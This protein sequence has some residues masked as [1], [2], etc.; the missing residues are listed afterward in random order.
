MS[1]IKTHMALPVQDLE[2]TRRFYSQLFDSEPAKVKEDY[3]KFAPAGIPINIAFVPAA[4]DQPSLTSLHLGLQF[5]DHDQLQQVYR[6]LQEQGLV[7]E[8]KSASVCC[9][10]LQDKF[11]VTDPDGYTWELYYLMEDSDLHSDPGSG[12]CDGQSR[13]KQ[14]CC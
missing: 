9:Y 13:K 5:T 4:G 7:R 8:E 3:L 10:A 11:R 14:A 2:K 6:S 1:A 12:C